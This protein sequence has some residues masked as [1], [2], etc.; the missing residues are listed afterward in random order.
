MAR[1][2]KDT[3]RPKLDHSSPRAYELS[4][5]LVLNHYNRLWDSDT[6]K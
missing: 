3:N 6:Y 2:K 4:L 5:A 1:I